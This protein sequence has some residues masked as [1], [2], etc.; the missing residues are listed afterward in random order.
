MATKE[1]LQRAVDMRV[2]LDS[3]VR[4]YKYDSATGG[5]YKKEF[6]AVNRDTRLLSFAMDEIGA[7]S[8]CYIMYAIIVLGVADL[9]GI[10]L[11]LKAMHAKHKDLSISDMS[12]KSID[13][14]RSRLHQL[15]KL[16]FLFRHCYSVTC[17][18]PKGEMSEDGVSLFTIT[19]SAQSFVDNKLEKTTAVNEWIQA[20][21][22][23]VLEGFAACAY[24]SGRI[25]QNKG[26]IEHKQGVFKTAA[27]GVRSIANV[28]KMSKN[29]DPS[30]PV[31]VGFMYSFRH[32]NKATQTMDDYHDLCERLGFM[33][34]QFLY[35]Y[36]SKKRVTRLV[37]V[38]E[39]NADLVEV[40]D[41]IVKNPNLL[42]DYDRIFFTGEGLIRNKAKD[43]TDF[44]DCFLKMVKAP[45]TKAKYVFVPAEP[46]FIS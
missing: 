41:I 17:R 13:A 26:Y 42:E 18:N 33:M 16:G 6:K 38:V 21:P 45:R 40:A 39:H 9:E 27:I 28:L 43:D 32:L 22:L 15:A 31:Y 36:D 1:E 29:D 11:F 46:D 4:R 23:Y 7:A 30:V 20:K 19:N 35:C 14:I 44:R 2:L 3:D 25:A 10:R 24:I 37:I 34:K 5:T 12:E 8:D